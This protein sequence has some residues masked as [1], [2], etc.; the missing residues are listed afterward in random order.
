[1]KKKRTTTV[2]QTIALTIAGILLASFMGTVGMMTSSSQLQTAEAS[3]HSVRGLYLWQTARCFDANSCN[4]LL[5]QTKAAEQGSASNLFMHYGF[6]D[7]PETFQVDALKAAVGPNDFLCHQL[8]MEGVSLPDL[9]VLADELVALEQHFNC[10]Q[11]M[12]LVY[13][14]ENRAETQAEF[15]DPLGSF[16]DAKDIANAH[17]LRLAASP[18]ESISIGSLADDIAGLVTIYHAQV[19]SEQNDDAD[20]SDLYTELDL[21][22]DNIR[23]S[24]PNKVITFQTA[25]GQG[26]APD[27]SGGTKSITE[28]ITDCMDAA[29]ANTSV[30]G[31]TVW[32]RGGDI[33]S[34]LWQ[35]LMTY[36]ETTFPSA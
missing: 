7:T 5:A 20:C 17:D 12:W 3:S 23:A 13:N 16:Q 15:A 8:G 36:W 35:N 11:D 24:H 26:A 6:G 29:Y 25:P 32:F 34:G 28:T 2:N 33:D 14:L 30:N 4:N 27:G 1:M 18:A 10:T 19:Q 31:A 9:E 21:I 22:I